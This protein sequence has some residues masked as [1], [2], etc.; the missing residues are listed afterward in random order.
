MIYCN[1]DDHKIF[2]KIII[3]NPSQLVDGNKVWVKAVE[4]SPSFIKV[5]VIKIIGH[6]DDIGI[7][8][9]SIVFGHGIE[10]EFSDEIIDYANNL[11]KEITQDEKKRRIDLTHLPIV[12]IDPSTSKDLD[13]AICVVKEENQYRLYVSIADVSHYVRPNTILDE[14]AKKRGTSIYLIDKVIPMLPHILSNDICS[15]NPEEETLT[16]TCEMV[17]KLDGSFGEIKV[18]D[19]IINS[20]KRFSYDEVNNY[21]KDNLKMDNISHKI[22]EMLDTSCELYEI[23]RPMLFKRGYIDFEIK[24]PKILLDDNGKVI[25][26]V[27]YNRGK[28]QMMI[29]NFMIA[30]NEATTLFYNDKFK[31]KDFVYRIHDKPSETKLAYFQAESKKM[32]FITKGDVFKIEPHTISNWISQ[33]NFV[34]P[35]KTILNKLLLKT[36]VKAEYSTKNIGHFGLASS[37]YTHFTSPI[38]RYP[39]ILVHRIFKMLLTD[40]KNYTVNDKIQLFDT[41]SLDCQNATKK[42]IQSVEIEREVNS[43]KYAEFMSTKIGEFYEGIVTHITGNGIFVELTNLIEGMVRL[44]NI[45]INDFFNYNEQENIL[46]GMK[47]KI[48]ISFGTRVKIKVMNVNIQLRQIDFSLLE[49]ISTI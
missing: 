31:D 40:T 43:L 45:K 41:L 49:I 30:A 3:V 48:Q 4:F 27:S 37:N 38:R 24:E 47:S 13:D 16:M 35:K 39:D 22:Y 34:E 17:I 26:V 7:D 29:E 14:E 36:M 20:R 25:D 6:R 1:L 9:Q 44:S 23:L 11:S 46:I 12:T 10:P 21:F 2:H 8:I 18:Y 33:N 15:L 32:N 42:E 19:S 28:A 5:E